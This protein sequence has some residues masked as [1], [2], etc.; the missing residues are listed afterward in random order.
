MDVLRDE[1]LRQA[2]AAL[3]TGDWG[4]IAERIDG[5]ERTACQLH[6]WTGQKRSGGEGGGSANILLRGIKCLVAFVRF[7]P[8]SL[9]ESLRQQLQLNSATV[10]L[11]P[12]M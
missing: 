2:V 5:R 11:R 4:V 10:V 8:I 6:W 12:D 1:K 3:G 7:P 9:R